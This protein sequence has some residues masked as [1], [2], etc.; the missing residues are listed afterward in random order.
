LPG[1]DVLSVTKDG[2]P[3]P[4]YIV[5]NVLELTTLL[6]DINVAGN[7]QPSASFRARR[8][9]LKRKPYAYE[10]VSSLPELECSNSNES[11]LSDGS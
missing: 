5:R 10:R 4:D 1:D 8:N 9:N 2:V 6:P 11:N 7:S 3:R